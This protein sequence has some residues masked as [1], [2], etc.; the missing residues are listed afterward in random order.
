MHS[1]KSTHERAKFVAEMNSK[2]ERKYRNYRR[3]MS[4]TEMLT[5]EEIKV[6][7]NT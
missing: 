1:K 2:W 5:D 3:W 6:L 7:S 4:D